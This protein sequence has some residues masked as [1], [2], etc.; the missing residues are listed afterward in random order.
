MKLIYYLVGGIYICVTHKTAHKHLKLLKKDNY[1]HDL[2]KGHW[3]GKSSCFV[4]SGL[5]F[6]VIQMPGT[7][8]HKLC[9]YRLFVGETTRS[10]FAH[11]F[12]LMR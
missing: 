7:I 12:V 4:E 1:T 2:I 6:P 3:S 8:R 9:F 11:T 5:L 10:P